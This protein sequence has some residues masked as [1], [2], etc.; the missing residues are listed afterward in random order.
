M[1]VGPS[2]A[3]EARLLDNAISSRS[4]NTQLALFNVPSTVTI[5][6]LSQS[7]RVVTV[8]ASGHGLSV[9]DI[10][11]IAG[12]TPAGYNGHYRVASVSG[13]QFTVNAPAGIGAATVLGTAGKWAELSGTG[14]AKVS[15][16]AAD[17][18]AATG[19]AP[20]TKTGPKTGTTWTFPQAGAAWADS[21]HPVVG[22]RLWDSANSVY[23]WA[24]VLAAATVVNALDTVYFDSSNQITMQGGDPDDPF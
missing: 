14:Y 23:Y 15:L 1:S 8:T 16:A 11:Q 7:G 2:N 13:T 22:W 5:T 18:N 4:G 19:G 9:D 17:W 24:G 12:M 20:T 21:S 10:V 6:A 3:E